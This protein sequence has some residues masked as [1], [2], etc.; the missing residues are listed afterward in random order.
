[1]E[2]LGWD[3]VRFNSAS[4]LKPSF[5]EK[6]CDILEVKTFCNQ[7]EWY[8]NSGYRGNTPA[9]GVS[10]SLMNA[11]LLQSVEAKWVNDIA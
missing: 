8:M 5:L 1:M 3:F 11:R 2:V 7:F 9:K 6:G 10:M 4:D